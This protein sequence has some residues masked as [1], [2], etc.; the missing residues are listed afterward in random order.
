MQSRR[1]QY[2]VTDYSGGAQLT[3]LGS[4]F[5]QRD[6]AARCL[7][8]LGYGHLSHVRRTTATIPASGGIPRANPPSSARGG[9]SRSSNSW[10]PF[11]S[12]I[13]PQCKRHRRSTTKTRT[14]HYSLITVHYL[15]DEHG[16]SNSTSSRRILF[17]PCAREFSHRLTPPR[18]ARWRPWRRR[19]KAPALCVRPD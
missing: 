11:P 3:S 9:S 15:K 1:H 13:K 14:S 7:D 8:C 12:P 4:V 18:P 16:G 17:K 10:Q 2:C 6:T 19:P 5:F